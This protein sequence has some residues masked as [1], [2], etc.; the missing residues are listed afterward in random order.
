MTKKPETELEKYLQQ[1]YATRP[2]YVPP[3]TNFAALKAKLPENP[4][5]PPLFQAIVEEDKAT[6]E[7]LIAAGAD[8]NEE[9]V[10]PYYQY[11]E[12]PLAIARKLEYPEIVKALKKAGAEQRGGRRGRGRSRRA[13]RNRRRTHRR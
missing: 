9:A 10:T 8:V 3:P 13:R 4:V 12:T 11:G 7:K 2:P 1:W 6:V 5:I